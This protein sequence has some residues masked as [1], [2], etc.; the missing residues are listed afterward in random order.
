MMVVDRP[1]ISGQSLGRLHGHFRGSMGPRIVGLPV[2]IVVGLLG[3]VRHD[4]PALRA[5]HAEAPF[6]KRRDPAF[7]NPNDEPPS[8]S[9]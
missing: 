6:R 7:G 1:T 2:R 4:P 8:L 9:A 5:H 3:H